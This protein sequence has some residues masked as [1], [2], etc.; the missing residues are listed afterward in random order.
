MTMEFFK[1]MHPMSWVLA[2]IMVLMIF[3]VVG[4]IIEINIDVPETAEEREELS[5]TTAFLVFL[6]GL[7]ILVIVFMAIGFYD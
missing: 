4:I 7:I 3:E 5:T 6:I 1:R 2:L